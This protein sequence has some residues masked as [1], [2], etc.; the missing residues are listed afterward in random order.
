MKTVGGG[1]PKRR[2]RKREGREKNGSDWRNI[3]KER[4][5]REKRREERRDFSLPTMTLSEMK[6]SYTPSG[7]CKIIKA[8]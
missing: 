6:Q 3:R 5:E 7:L 8:E 4:R 1:R 2:E